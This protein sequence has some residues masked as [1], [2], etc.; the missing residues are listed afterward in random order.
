MNTTDQNISKRQVK[1]IEMLNANNGNIP[2][3]FSY[4]MKHLKE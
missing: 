4:Q 3:Q 1:D 2:F